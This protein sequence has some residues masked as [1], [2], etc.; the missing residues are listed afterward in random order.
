MDGPKPIDYPDYLDE[1]KQRVSE[2]Q[3]ENITLKLTIKRLR[4]YASELQA[5]VA[6][7]QIIR[8][9]EEDIVT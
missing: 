4:E 9:D 6:K 1:Y 2:L 7:Q 8:K 3:H 5:E